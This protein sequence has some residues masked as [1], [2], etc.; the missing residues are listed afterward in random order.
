VR[1]AASRSG[2]SLA[3]RAWA[4]ASGWSRRFDRRS[5]LRRERTPSE[6]LPGPLSLLPFPTSQD[7]ARKPRA[8]ARS[9]A[10]SGAPAALDEQRPDFARRRRLAGLLALGFLGV[11]GLGGVASVE[12]SSGEEPDRLARERERGATAAAQEGKGPPQR[13]TGRYDR[14]Q[15][16]EKLDLEI[17]LADARVVGQT[18]AVVP[19]RAPPP[20]TIAAEFRV[21]NR[22]RSASD[23]RPHLVA[24]DEKGQVHHGP[25]GAPATEPTVGELRIPPGGRQH[26]YLSVRA[27]DGA[28]IERLE[29]KIAGQSLEW[30][31]ERAL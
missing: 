15:G 9:A 8:R 18:R 27:P 13:A 20:R 3:R 21:R 31:L 30:D 4:N 16:W 22:S 6:A 12:R 24:L 11:V 5:G 2:A 10:R 28:T 25:E 19:G 29:L 23:E 17:G 7:S 1:G 14:G 26:G